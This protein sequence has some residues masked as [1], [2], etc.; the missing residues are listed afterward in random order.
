MKIVLRLFFLLICSFA[1]SQDIQWGKVSQQEI[2]LDEV[3]FEPGADAVKLKDIG[4][5][6]ITDRGYELVEYGRTKILSIN[7][8]ENA[9]KKWSYRPAVFNDKVVL[10]GA[11]TINIIDGKSV[12]TPV[13]KKDI[14]ISRNGNI[15]EIALAFPN[16][17]VGS[18]IE[19]KVKI[20]RPYDLYASPWR[21]Q[22]SIPTLSSQ[23]YL[24]LATGFN[25]KVI[26]KGQKLNQKYSGKKNNKEWELTNI[27]S[28]KIYKNVYNI[29]DYRERLMFQYTSAKNYYGTY[30]SENSWGGF[31]KIIIKDIQQ[32]SKNVDFQRIAA[33]IK[34]GSTQLET[35][36]N[37]VQFLRDHY[38]RNRFLA[39]KTSDIQSDFLKT[40]IG[41]AADFNILLKG[42]LSIKNI[43]S[44][45]AINSPRSNGRIIVAY[46]TFSK[47]QTLVN[48]VEVDHGEKLL[49]DGATSQA[50]N[51][52]FLSLNN[53]NYIVLGLD[54]PG[55]FFIT[56]SPSLSEFVSRQ[57]LEIGE[58]DSSVD[59]QNRTNGYFNLENFNQEVFNVFTGI[60][61][62]DTVKKESD[63]WTV[64]Q[65]TIDFDNPANSVFVIENPFTKSL[66]KLTVE[67]N[68]D[69]PI[70]LDF[71]FLATIQLRTQLP[72]N[73]K[74]DTEDFQHK[75]SAFKGD[76]QYLQE[77]EIINNEKLITWSLLINKTIF[78]NKEIQEYNEFMDKVTDAFSKVAVIRKK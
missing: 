75:I 8:F 24:D 14:I 59:I 54:S 41:N 28:D 21:F 46:P 50:E 65:R 22:N 25:Y 53:F 47:L 37:C 38:K 64:T 32:S 7:G 6:K 2:D 3:A 48:I 30:Y 13:D 26:L 27:P 12:I 45:L 68:R 57:N 66:K 35:L 74:L 11:Q 73:Y 16:V 62:A 70:E 36:K 15:E 40:K 43:Q 67:K 72:E 58:D 9:E 63:E 76:L 23:L 78:Q 18:M 19:Y 52:R 42:I 31:K 39:V 60:K 34:N 49:I 5:L 61:T 51:I 10:Q 69:F 77:V 1:F 44:E 29:E 17:R 56:V 4:L 33:Q 20:M 55:E 71:P